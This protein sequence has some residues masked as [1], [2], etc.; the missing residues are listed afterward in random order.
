MRKRRDDDHVR[1]GIRRRVKTNHRGRVES[2][3]DDIK[4]RLA[5]LLCDKFRRNLFTAWTV[6]GKKVAGAYSWL[7]Q[8]T[9]EPVVPMLREKFKGRTR[10]NE[11]TDAE[12]RG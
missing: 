10:K 8:G 3:K 9:W 6:P 11:R 7:L 2:V 5:P 4:S 1:R 12:H